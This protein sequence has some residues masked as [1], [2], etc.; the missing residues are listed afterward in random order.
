MIPC[1]SRVNRLC[2]AVET[3]RVPTKWPQQTRAMPIFA[4]R[5]QNCAVR[6][7]KLSCLPSCLTA[8]DRFALVLAL[9]FRGPC[10][11]ATYTAWWSR[12]IT[13]VNCMCKPQTSCAYCVA[14]NKVSISCAPT[15]A[16]SSGP[17]AWRRLICKCQLSIHTHTDTHTHIRT[18]TVNAFNTL[19][20][21][22]KQDDNKD[23]RQEQQQYVAAT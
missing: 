9:R 22:G 20:N 1:R 7:T 11:T 21:Y 16:E 17:F 6:L 15:Y 5:L 13:H 23:R 18:M 10:H 12:K 14:A 3:T 4:D 8:F 2:P 19:R